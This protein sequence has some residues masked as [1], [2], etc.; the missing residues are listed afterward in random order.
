[1][2]SG[3]DDWIY[4]QFF[5]IT[6]N[7]NSSHIELLLNDVCL[8]NLSEESLTALNDVCLT[9]EFLMSLHGSLYRLARIHG[10]P[11]KWF[12]FTKT[13][14]PKRW[15]IS[16][17]GPIVDCVTLGMY[18]PK[19]CLADGHIP[20]EYFKRNTVFLRLMRCRLGQSVTWRRGTPACVEAGYCRNL[21]AACKIYQKIEHFQTLKCAVICGNCV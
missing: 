17:W 12:V 21:L 19:R 3:F 18:L 8:T 15:L 20:W 1:M 13:C 6:V 5:T 16:N 4:W 11:C 10:N 7:Y 2:G 14:L 9:N